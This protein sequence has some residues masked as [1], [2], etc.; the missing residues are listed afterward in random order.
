M[1]RNLFKINIYLLFMV[2][3][4]S[5]RLDVQSTPIFLQ[6]QEQEWIENLQKPLKIGITE[7]PNQILRT[8]NGY[9]GFSIDIFN[10]IESLL[11]IEF[12]YI[13]YETREELLVAGK[14]REVDII[15]SAQKSEAKLAYYDFTD[16]ILKEQHIVGD[17][18]YDYNL[19]IASRNDMPTLSVI[20]S[21]TV[22]AISASYIKTLQLKWGYIQERDHN[23]LFK[24]IMMGFFVI[25]LSILLW[26]VMLRRDNK[27]LQEIL[28]SSIA[29]MAI[30][31]DGKCIHVNKMLLATSGYNA[32]E[33]LGKKIENFIC[34]SDHEKLKERVKTSQEG[35]EITLKRKNGTMYPA[36]VKG[37]NVTG[38]RRISSFIDISEIKK[39]H[40]ELESFNATLEQKIEEAIK[41][42]KKQE[43]MLSQQ[44]RLAQMGEAIN[45]IAHQW[46]QPLH[47]INGLVMLMDMK[48]SK[49]D[50]KLS[51]LLNKELDEIESLTAYMSNTIDDFRNFFKPEKSK[52][53]FNLRETIETTFKVLKPMLSYDKIT[54]NNHYSDEVIL[55]GYPNE[56]SQVIISIVNNAKD[57][58]MF[59]NQKGE[60]YI[61]THLFKEN[62]RA[63]ITIQDNAGGIDTEII[64]YIFDPYFSTKLKNGTGLGL[65]ISKMIIEEHMGGELSVTNNES[66]ALFRIEFELP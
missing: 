45:M 50:N 24:K 37:T 29:S 11:E 41:K 16:S 58:L 30:F 17:I 19:H 3:L 39:A 4:L 36:L 43:Q 2:T 49:K 56:L 60:K 1:L 33:V 26:V 40:Y 14:R 51:L 9:E 8:K 42:N 55:F 5:A 7:N 31:K 13:Y 66:G 44:A 34:P 25:L 57:V 59:N 54:I 22:D 6:Q 28:D 47:N 65:Y 27:K 20:L 52:V 64:E 10:K 53:Q 62:N 48:L 38:N 18:G 32:R 61:T 21:K 23:L 35:Y 46:R 15:F 12:E 63:V